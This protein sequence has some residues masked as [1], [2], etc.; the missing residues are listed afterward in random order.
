MSLTVEEAI[1]GG[2]AGEEERIRVR[3]RDLRALIGALESEIADVSAPPGVGCAQAI[4]HAAADLA[5]YVARLDVK[6]RLLEEAKRDAR[7][8]ARGKAIAPTK[9]A[10]P[11]CNV[12]NDTHRMTLG[13]RE[14][15]C[16]HCPR[17]CE[18][19][20]QHLGAFCEKTPC[21]CAC[22]QRGPT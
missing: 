22:H 7:S 4:A 20:R 9:P 19:C 16:T 15:M 10:S 11:I 6:R 3:I 21:S 14:V 18:R 2:M 17:P 5:T 12:C 1:A 13:E 8:A